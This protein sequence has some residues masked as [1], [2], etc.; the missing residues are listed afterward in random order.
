MRNE[1]DEIERRD[2]QGNMKNGDKGRKCEINHSRQITTGI[3]H[4]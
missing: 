1:N 4:T 2:E 3:F